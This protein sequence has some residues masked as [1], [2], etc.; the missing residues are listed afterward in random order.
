M[1]RF[2]SQK[3]FTKFFFHELNTP[4]TPFTYGSG[5]STGNVTTTWP[6]RKPNIHLWSIPLFIFRQKKAKAKI[7]RLSQQNLQQFAV[8]VFSKK[9]RK[10]E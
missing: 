10:K 2:S 9:K 6:T 3:N 7:F 1:I 5:Q 4:A 8:A